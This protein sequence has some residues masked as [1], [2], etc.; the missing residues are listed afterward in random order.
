MQVLPKNNGPLVRLADDKPTG[1]NFLIQLSPTDADF[2]AGL[3]DGE[4]T[5]HGQLSEE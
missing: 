4:C 1:R 2:A 5:F 3:I